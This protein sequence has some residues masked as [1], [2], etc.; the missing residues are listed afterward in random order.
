[1]GKLT[2]SKKKGA[3]DANHQPLANVET[4]PSAAWAKDTLDGAELQTKMKAATKEYVRMNRDTETDAEPSWIPKIYCTPTQTVL[5]NYNQEWI[6]LTPENLEEA[7]KEIA[8]EDGVPVEFYVRILLRDA[9]QFA[10]LYGRVGWVLP[11]L[12]REVAK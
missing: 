2:K 4:A 7:G 3:S 6:K 11:R 9:R 10:K 1:M 12:D 5:F 8:E